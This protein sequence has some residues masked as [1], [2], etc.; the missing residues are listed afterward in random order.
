MVVLVGGCCSTRNAREV[1][2][3]VNYLDPVELV[4]TLDGA[5]SKELSIKRR[6]NGLGMALKRSDRSDPQ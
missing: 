2:I 3:L 6:G 5:T 4:H 1:V